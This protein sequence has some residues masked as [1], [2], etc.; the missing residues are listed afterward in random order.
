MNKKAARIIFAILLTIAFALFAN[1]FTNAYRAASENVQDVYFAIGLSF[2]GIFFHFSKN[3]PKAT[4]RT[5]M[6]AESIELLMLVMTPTVVS[7]RIL[8]DIFPNNAYAIIIPTVLALSSWY[9]VTLIRTSRIGDVVNGKNAYS[10]TMLFYWGIMV[11][12][13]LLIL[14]LIH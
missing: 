1:L 4:K 6:T 14:L 8:R 5:K 7:F 12:V 3:H 10:M 2:G 11:F 13:V 9:I